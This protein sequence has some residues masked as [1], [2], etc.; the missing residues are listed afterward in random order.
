MASKIQNNAKFTKQQESLQNWFCWP[1][2]SIKFLSKEMGGF[3]QITQRKGE[4]KGKMVIL[5]Y[6]SEGVG[7]SNHI[8]KLHQQGI[9]S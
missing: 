8:R 4:F 2:E 7:I 5:V 6:I 9:N 3:S 1:P